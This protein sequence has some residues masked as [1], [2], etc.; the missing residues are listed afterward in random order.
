MVTLTYYNLDNATSSFFEENTT[1][2]RQQCEEWALSRVGA[3]AIP[4][5]I[6]GAY[7]YTFTAGD[8]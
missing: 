1:V 4:V 5:E 8:R 2:T 3:Q 7:S 6:Q